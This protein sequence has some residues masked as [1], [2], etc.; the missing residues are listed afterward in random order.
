MKRSRPIIIVIVLIA[1]AFLAWRLLAPSREPPALSGYIEGETLFLAAPVA[2]TLTS[3]AAIEGQRVAGG[4]P[5]FTIDPATLSAQGEQ[6]RARIAEA[7]TQIAAAQATVQQAESEAAAAAADAD[8]AKR[9]LN[10]L[11][12]VRRIDP[13]AVAGK[14]VDAAQAALREANAR[15][16]AARDSAAA[17]RSQVG[18]ARAQQDQARGG[19][20]E[21]QIR[22]GQ[23]SPSAPGPASVEDVFFRPGEWVAANQPVLAL[24]PDSQVKVRFFVPEREV[25]R[26][27]PGRT[28][29]F[30]CDACPSGL[31][32]R[33]TYVSPR[34]EFTPPIIYSRDSRDRLVFMVE[35][36]PDRPRRLMP[37]LPV[38]VEP[39]P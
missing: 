32:A 31:S 30:A 36:R 35:A 17:R 28:I 22:V 11:L 34:P 25:A 4:A 38:D 7:G 27:R 29:R 6:A 37:G 3:L 23:L 39:L 13:A 19:A 33:I 2:G 5:L 16:A 12:A 26:Y 14:D 9:D 8:K 21:V 1:A 20:R 15:L 24:L 18:A 10:R